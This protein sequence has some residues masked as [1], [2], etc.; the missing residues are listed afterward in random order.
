M[1]LNMRVALS[2]MQ[3][4]GVGIEDCNAVVVDVLCRQLVA[5]IPQLDLNARVALL[6]ATWAYSCVP[7]LRRVPIAIIETWP[8]RLPSALAGAL[9]KLPSK[10]FTKLPRALR[11]RC[12][13]LVPIRF[14]T[15]LASLIERW[16][17][18]VAPGMAR[19]LFIKVHSRP[20]KGGSMIRR[21]IDPSLYV[22]LHE[23]IGHDDAALLESFSHIIFRGVK[24]DFSHGRP[25]LYPVLLT[26]VVLGS[27]VHST[28]GLRRLAA[29]VDMV[30]VNG[31]WDD[32]SLARL[33]SVLRSSMKPK[34]TDNSDS[35]HEAT[36]SIF[37]DSSR[38]VASLL[39]I[40]PFSIAFAAAEITNELST[41]MKL[42]LL[43]RQR[44]RI[45][46][47]HDVVTTHLASRHAIGLELHYS[48]ASAQDI[49]ASAPQLLK[50]LW[51]T[52]SST[53]FAGSFQV[54]RR[55][56]LPAIH[57]HSR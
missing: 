32:A 2:L 8:G 38:L 33:K 6:E 47:L 11:W 9:H 43:P 25:S 53:L 28:E 39:L 15:L 31:T 35:S 55:T 16:F 10:F 51:M 30:A 21:A 46:K 14:R 22:V 54:S 3:H 17:S 44:P 41:C 49:C 56:K 7:E 12:C 19:D 57:S 26:D 24:S 42:G 50:H 18:S 29:V 5:V 23:V 34:P 52:K 13:A 1:T 40:E 20:Y 4:G 45:D 48:P 37:T 36:P 27:K